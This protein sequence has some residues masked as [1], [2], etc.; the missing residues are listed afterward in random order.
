MYCGE[1][2]TRSAV[3]LPPRR[4]EVNDVPSRGGGGGG[5]SGGGGGMIENKNQYK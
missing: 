2:I 1:R 3:S 4:A 5:G